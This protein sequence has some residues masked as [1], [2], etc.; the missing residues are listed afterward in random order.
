MRR[1]FKINKHTSIT[2]SRHRERPNRTDW[3]YKNKFNWVLIF[4]KIWIEVY[5]NSDV[6]GD[7]PF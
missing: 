3:K 6:Y 2:I 5:S 1:T 4:E 7:L